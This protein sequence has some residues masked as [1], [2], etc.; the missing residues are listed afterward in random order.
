MTFYQIFPLQNTGQQEPS[1]LDERYS[2]DS[3]NFSL[4]I[5]DVR[6]ADAAS[7]YQCVLGVVE[8]RANQPIPFGSTQDVN[9]SLSLNCK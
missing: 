9:L 1:V 6:V 3:Q 8:P 4:F 2:L 7:D 5:S